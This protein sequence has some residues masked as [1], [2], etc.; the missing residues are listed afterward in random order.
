[1]RRG[2]VTSVLWLVCFAASGCHHAYT[3]RMVA[4]GNVNG[5]GVSASTAVDCLDLRVHRDDG[6][7][8][9]A[10]GPQVIVVAIEVGNACTS[11]R[12]VALGAVEATIDR[13]DHPAESLK[14]LDPRRE[15]H[16]Y[17]V[18]AASQGTAR[19]AFMR[20]DAGV[21]PERV[22]VDFSHAVDAEGWLAP[23]C[24]EW[25][26]PVDASS[27]WEV[28]RHGYGRGYRECV[29]RSHVVGQTRCSGFASDWANGDAPAIAV[30]VD[31]RALR[32]A[33]SMLVASGSLASQAWSLE[34]GPEPWLVSLAPRT[35]I[36][37]ERFAYVGI[38][39]RLGVGPSVDGTRATRTHEVSVEPGVSQLLGIG[40]VVG[41]QVV[42]APIGLRAELFAGADF[43]GIWARTSYLGVP[44]H[45]SVTLTP[46]AVIEPRLAVD[47]WLTPW[48]SVGVMGGVDV[49]GPLTSADVG[50]TITGHVRSYDA[51][52]P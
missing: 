31:V 47:L 46:H 43:A 23:V 33:P 19:V 37:L 26:P 38:E 15:L 13:A 34:S 30:G 17:T 16:T 20:T 12:R 35:R 49:L 48:L 18:D 8:A 42:L 3:E 5:M 4:S 24:F 7:G 52:Q 14:R 21:A 40:G 9:A 50:L 22:C 36:E 27:G 28:E 25:T 2:V 10:L 44:G 6:L 1:M 51:A 11:P 39:G 41:M 29:E 45:S 32:L